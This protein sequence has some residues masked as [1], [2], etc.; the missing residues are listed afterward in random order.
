MKQIAKTDL[1]WR[2]MLLSGEFLRD[3]GVSRADVSGEPLLCGRRTSMRVLRL[4]GGAS[5]TLDSL[6]AERFIYVV[7]GEV[8][9][10]DGRVSENLRHGDALA[11]PPKLMLRGGS[12][13]CLLLVGE[14]A[15]A[16]GRPPVSLYSETLPETTGMPSSRKKMSDM[17]SS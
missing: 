17:P 15:V 2:D 8:S 3:S 11:A 16:Q 12:D 13:G 4:T 7:W 9:I 5:L 1:C 14:P 10:S 6:P